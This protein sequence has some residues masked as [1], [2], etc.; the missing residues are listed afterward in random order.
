MFTHRR[1]LYLAPRVDAVSGFLTT[2]I[3]FRARK[4][5]YTRKT[6]PIVDVMTIKVT[7]YRVPLRSSV[8]KYALIL[9]VSAVTLLYVPPSSVSAYLPPAPDNSKV[10]AP[11]TDPV[12][13]LPGMSLISTSNPVYSFHL[14]VSLAR[15][16][17]QETT[18]L[19]STVELLLVDEENRLYGA[20]FKATIAQ[21][22]ADHAG[23]ISR[24]W[25]LDLLISQESLDRGLADM[26]AFSPRD[27]S[28]SQDLSL[29]VEQIGEYRE[30]QHIA[31]T[32]EVAGYLLNI[33]EAQNRYTLTKGLLEQVSV[34]LE[35]SLQIVENAQESLDT[36]L[37]QKMSYQTVVAPD[38]CPVEVP[39]D[40]LREYEGTV[41]G[42][43]TR[44]VA[45]APTPQA[46]L[47]IKY[48]FRALGSNY[49]CDDI[50]RYAAFSYDCSSLVTRSYGT[51]AGMP[52]LD[53]IGPVSTRQMV[54]WG[55]GELVSWLAPVAEDL[56][57]PGDIVLYDT[58]KVDTRHVVIMLADGMMIHT[59]NCGDVAHIR[60]F[61][62]FENSYYYNYLGSRRIVPQT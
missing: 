51:G 44:S 52:I 53:S 41:W 14:D 29:W 50:S 28:I 38:G 9:V 36:I 6:G 13:D 27:P 55:G 43:C 21:A 39:Y 31:L 47:A 8:K 16:T 2:T 26:L 40:T 25:N 37:G 54:P 60:K 5:K 49:A 30:T 46:A 57:L 12:Q 48:A 34:D 32:K 10:D 11:A 17:L 4:R 3:K 33:K 42:L 58:F 19:K 1:L 61:W 56:A 59:D 7:V 62:G 18:L 15:K 20:M 45:Q 23:K 22:K 35:N 24:Q